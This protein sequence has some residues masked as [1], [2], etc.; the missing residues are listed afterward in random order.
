MA[1]APSRQVQRPPEQVAAQRVVTQHQAQHW[2]GP[3]PRP[4][5]L[6]NFND[7]I[8]DGADRIMKM[9]EQEQAHRIAHDESV[10]K[11]LA[12]DTKRGHF[13]GAFISVFALAGAVITAY[14]GAHP[15][16]SIALVGLPVATIIQA[17][18]SSRKSG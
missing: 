7:I 1:K 8:P 18:I 12:G 3:L 2:S 16:V 5:D 9:V 4:S 13:L 14:F 17:F 6:A 11:A 10:M 15:T